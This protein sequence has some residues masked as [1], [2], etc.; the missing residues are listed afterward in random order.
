MVSK[1]RVHTLFGFANPFLICEKCKSRTPYWH[2]PEHCGPTG[3]CGA[4]YYLEPCGHK[5]EAISRCATWHPVD[6]CSCETLC[7]K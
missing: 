4:G 7:I 1:T 6:G 5:A 3:D 2:N